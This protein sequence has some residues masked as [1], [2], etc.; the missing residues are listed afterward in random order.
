MTK[1]DQ[2]RI[3][4]VMRATKPDQTVFNDAW[5]TWTSVVMKLREELSSMS[6]RFD[7]E[8]FERACYE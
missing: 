6:E 7:G 3:A 2:D 4:K 1:K 5:A 8:R